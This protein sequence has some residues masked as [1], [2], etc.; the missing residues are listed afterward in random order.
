MAVGVKT[1]EKNKT[2]AFFSSND[3]P[4][5]RKEKNSKDKYHKAYTTGRAVW[6]TL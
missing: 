1:S 4:R 3:K 6:C 2:A 5:E